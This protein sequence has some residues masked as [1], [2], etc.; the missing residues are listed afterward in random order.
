MP[1]HIVQ[2]GECLSRIAAQYGFRDYLTV[3]NDPG[4]ADLRKKRPDPNMLF[5][6]DVIFIPDKTS[7]VVPAET[8]KEHQFRVPGSQRFLRIRVEDIDG[9]KVVSKPYELE[10]E[11]VITQ[12]VTGPDG[13][14][15][16][17]I[18]VHAEN[19]SLTVGQHS[20]P[21][22]I[23]HLNPLDDVDDDGV[24]GIQ[25]RLRNMGY[26]PGPIDGI[27]GPLTKAAIEEFQEDNPP[28]AVDG[29]CGP[30]TRARLVE[31][32]GC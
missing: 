22:A 18:P 21:L 30:L 26:D 1:D 7:K 15:Q 10:I 32:Y 23:A 13:V 31:V 9:K 29:I 5:P 11:G 27:M 25:G 24:S 14:I 8:A 17:H 20:W 3:Y 19:G 4:N 28:L 6:G 12:G 2:Q 16:Q